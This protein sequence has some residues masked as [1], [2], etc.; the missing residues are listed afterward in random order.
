LAEGR[1][2][3]R[4]RCDWVGRGDWGQNLAVRF[5]YFLSHMYALSRIWTTTVAKWPLS[6]HL[7]MGPPS[8]LLRWFAGWLIGDRFGVLVNC[9]QRVFVVSILSVI[10]S[11]ADP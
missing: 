5:S 10:S 7:S 9:Y 2:E 3:R 1:R 11:I 4:Q 8:G 6:S